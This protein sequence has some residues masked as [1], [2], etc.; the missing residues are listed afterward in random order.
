VDNTDE[1]HDLRMTDLYHETTISVDSGLRH[2]A[3]TIVIPVHF[4]LTQFL[5]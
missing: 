1:E 5:Q 3:D 4:D 2:S